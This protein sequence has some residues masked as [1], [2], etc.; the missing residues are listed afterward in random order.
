MSVREEILRSGGWDSTHYL[1]KQRILLR[2][3]KIELMKRLEEADIN[4]VSYRDRELMI[5]LKVC[6]WDLDEAF[7]FLMNRVYTGPFVMWKEKR[8]LKEE[9]R[10][11]VLRRLTVGPS[12]IMRSSQPNSVGLSSRDSC[13]Q[14]APNL[15]SRGADSFT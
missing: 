11:C 2:T 6:N 8:V 7:Q 14:S 12:L 4:G 1:N 13:N 10:Y 5:S 9:V 3:Y 15:T